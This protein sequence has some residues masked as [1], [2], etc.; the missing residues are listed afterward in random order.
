MARTG[1]EQWLTGCT[2]PAHEWCPAF[3]GREATL[4][5]GD[6]LYTL[7]E[8]GPA[9]LVSY[10]GM[11][12]GTQLPSGQVLTVT[13]HSRAIFGFGLPLPPRAVHGHDF[14]YG[15]LG[16]TAGLLSLEDMQSYLELVPNRLQDAAML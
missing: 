3:L 5:R 16:S 13:R 1:P 15:T 10:L 2:V 4:L 9:L 7:P 11:Q 8:G 14:L 12:A 6:Q